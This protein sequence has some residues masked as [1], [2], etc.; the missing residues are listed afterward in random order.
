MRENILSG[1]KIAQIVILPLPDVQ[2]EESEE[3][4][5]TERGANG[6]GS[7]GRF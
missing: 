2:M 5:E 6:F 4:E 1:E 7:S 3:L